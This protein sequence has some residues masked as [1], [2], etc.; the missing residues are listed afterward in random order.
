[1][2]VAPASRYYISMTTIN[3]IHLL[4]LI[5]LYDVYTEF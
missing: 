5:K 3:F 1:M 4:F 2:I